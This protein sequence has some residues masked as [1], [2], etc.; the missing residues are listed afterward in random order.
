MIRSARETVASTLVSA[1]MNAKRA[2]LCGIPGRFTSTLTRAVVAA[3]RAAST[4]AA[5]SL[6]TVRLATGSNSSVSSMTALAAQGCPP[7][8][9]V[10][11]ATEDESTAW[12]VW[13]IAKAARQTE[14]LA[15]SSMSVPQQAPRTFAAPSSR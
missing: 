7:K 6:M 2:S 11:V 4:A 12:Y 14:S 15:T 3:A 9:A 8:L 13:S 5:T 1:S 10:V